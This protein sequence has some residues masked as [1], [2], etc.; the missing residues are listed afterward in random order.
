MTPMTQNHII[1]IKAVET[2]PLYECTL[3]GA[4]VQTFARGTADRHRVQRYYTY[5]Y[6][7]YFVDTT[8]FLIKR[9]GNGDGNAH[10]CR[11]LSLRDWPN[12]RDDSKY[13]KSQLVSRRPT[14]RFIMSKIKWM[15]AEWRNNLILG[16]SLRAYWVRVLHANQSTSIISAFLKMDKL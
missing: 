14:N 5:K 3:H 6:K 15:T 12:W 11:H 2:N 9:H 7:I 16:E 1:S 10:F 8:E 4:S 13:S